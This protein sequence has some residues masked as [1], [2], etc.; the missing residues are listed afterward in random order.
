M[1]PSAAGG[2]HNPR[3]AERSARGR[4]R[5]FRRRQ[6]LCGMPCRRNRALEGIPPRAGDAACHAGHGA[7]R[8]RR[9]GVRSLRDRHNV[10]PRWRQVH[11][12]HRRPDG[13]LHD[14]EIA[15]TFGVYP[16]QQYLIAMPG[17]RLQALGIAWDS[18]SKEQGGQRWFHLYPDQK[19]PAGDR[20]H[21]T[22]RDQTWNYK[23]ARL[24]LHQPE[25]ELRSR[26]QQLCNHLD[27]RG[28]VLRSLPRPGLSS[29]CLGEI[30]RTGPCRNGAEGPRGLAAAKRQ[31]TLGDEPGNRNRA[32]GREPLVSQELDVCASCHSRRKVIAPGPVAG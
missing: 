5:S 15:Y 10:L 31:R 27:R 1:C 20:L 26:Q 25:E 19:L 29:C 16:L 30:A 18:R 14:F 32:D 2:R 12:A 13:A 21:W 24:P 4:S 17:G 23:C 3:V 22:G 8:F 7:R 9:S 11:G 6:G 28:C